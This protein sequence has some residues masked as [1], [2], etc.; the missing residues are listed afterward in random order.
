MKTTDLLDNLQILKEFEEREFDSTRKIKDLTLQDL[1][2]IVFLMEIKHEDKNPTY[3]D[4]SEPKIDPE[5]QPELY[6]K[7]QKKLKKLFM[8]FRAYT[9][10]KSLANDLDS[11]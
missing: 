11:L 4:T 10:L 7:R 9:W 5:L 3:L 1:H 2:T 6:E 8:L